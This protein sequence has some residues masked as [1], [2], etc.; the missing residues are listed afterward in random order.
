MKKLLLTTLMFICAFGAKA[1]TPVDATIDTNDILYWVGTGSNRAVLIVNFGIPDTALAWGFRFNGTATV[2]QMTDSI[3]VNDPRFWVV[4]LPSWYPQGDIFYVMDNN[5]TLSLSGTS[6]EVPFNYW[7]A[8]INGATSF[9]GANEVLHDG[10]VFKYGDLASPTRVCVQDYGGY[11]GLSA[12]T[13]TPVPVPVPST[14]NGPEEA[15]IAASDILYWV[16]TGSNEVVF[17]VNWADTALAWGYRFDG[18]AVALSAVMNDIQSA[19]PRFSYSL[20]SYGYLSDI[21]FVNG[22]DTLGVTPYNYFEHKTNGEYGMGL[23]SQLHDGDFAKWADPAAG[24]IV[25]STYFEDNGGYWMY[26]YIY[27]MAISPVSVPAAAL[28]EEATIAASDILYWVGTG[29]N[30]VVFAVN[31]ADTAL[32]WGYR[33]DGDAVALSAVMND[34][35]SA[36]PRFSYSLNSYGYLSDIRFVNGTDTLGVTPYNYFEHKTNG[37]YGMGLYSQLHDGDFAKWADP[38]AGTIVDSTYFEDNGGYWMYTYIYDMAISP[39][40]VPAAEHGPFCGIVGSE[41]CNA[42]AGNSSDI[43]AWATGCVVERGLQNI[44][45]PDGPRATFGDETMAI[46]PVDM[47]DNLSV[48][49]LGDA[50]VA[51]LTFDHPITNG[52]GPDF[53][54]FENSFGDYFLELAFVEVSSDG[55]HF[56]RFAATSLTQTETQ[57][58]GMG[59]LDPTYI[60]NLAGKFRFGYG[61]PFDLEE[62]ADVE[63]LD[64]NNVT[65]VRLVDVVGSIDPEYATY[66]AEGRIINDPWPTLAAGSGFDLDGVAVLHRANTEDIDVA[67][68]TALS[69]YPNPAA[70]RLYVVLPVASEAQLFDMSGRQLMTISLN[71]GTNA[72]D[73]SGLPQGIYL[74]RAAGQTVKVVKR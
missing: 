20:N 54:V 15:T 17:A 19:D 53:A 30:E 7:E 60:N 71:A 35:Q 55:E 64:V 74:L 31:W 5:D 72:I 65:H 57:V 33:F 42:I 4:G 16:G 40:S 24:T 12:W 38:A 41:G 11:C 73:L 49:S 43:K 52:E 28:P 59:S 46:G 68:P 45:N 63:G 36:D 27:D 58:G 44:A 47:G 62:L 70:E 10:D 22:T 51:T 32:A 29:S 21:R 39:V 66:D 37:E 3:T 2:Q 1:Q 8:N 23:Y 69:V 14:S 34:I 56:F 67:E 61:T 48:V 25:D 9:G 26:T 13:K 6:A 50:G 18:D